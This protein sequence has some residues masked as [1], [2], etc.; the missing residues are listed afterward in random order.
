MSSSRAYPTLRDHIHCRIKFWPICFTP[1]SDIH[2]KKRAFK[3]ANFQKNELQKNELSKRRTTKKRSFRKANSKKANFQKGEHI[4]C[5]TWYFVLRRC[6]K[7]EHIY[8]FLLKG[9]WGGGEGG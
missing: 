5:H 9:K 2:T 8:G 1:P 4:D 3:K 6:Q 7:G